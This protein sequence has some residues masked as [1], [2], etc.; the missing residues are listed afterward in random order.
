MTKITLNQFALTTVMILI[1]TMGIGAAAISY[2]PNNVCY[3]DWK[4]YETSHI[5]AT[6]APVGYEYVVATLYLKN[7]GDHKITTSRNG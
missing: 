7:I 6:Q 1:L 4:W 5:S 3:W 2:D